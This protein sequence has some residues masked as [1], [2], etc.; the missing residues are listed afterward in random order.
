MAK[1]S[2]LLTEKVHQVRYGRLTALKLKLHMMLMYLFQYFA[3]F[4]ISFGKNTVSAS[5]TI[6]IYEMCTSTFFFIENYMHFMT[7]LHQA[8]I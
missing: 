2:S 4:K 6:K 5:S 1:V 8:T 3:G 7:K